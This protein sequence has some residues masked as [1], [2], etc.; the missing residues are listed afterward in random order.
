MKS[1]FIANIFESGYNS[2]PNINNFN[3]VGEKTESTDVFENP[4]KALIESLDATKVRYG[5]EIRQYLQLLWNEAPD[6]ADAKDPNLQEKMADILKGM[7][8]IGCAAPAEAV[9]NMHRVFTEYRGYGANEKASDDVEACF[10]EKFEI[11]ETGVIVVDT[12]VTR[13]LPK[14]VEICE[15]RKVDLGRIRVRCPRIVLAAQLMTM[16]P[17]KKAQME[18]VLSKLD[19]SQFLVE[20][21]NSPHNTEIPG[22][23][24]I[25]VHF[26]PRTLPFR[27]EWH[28]KAHVPEG[29]K[30]EVHGEVLT[31]LH[32]MDWVHEEV[33]QIIPGGRVFM[34]IAVVPKFEPLGVEMEKG[35][36]RTLVR[37]VQQITRYVAECIVRT[38]K[39]LGMEILD[40]EEFGPIAGY[41]HE[42]VI[43]GLHV[44]KP[45]DLGVFQRACQ[46]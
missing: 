21:A 26:T 43:Q 17:G 23:S 18:Q 42:K 40:G 33:A 27:L 30:E 11:P 37:P 28:E 19:K 45:K 20:D 10:G 22:S 12:F 14:I 31:S 4:R 46:T 25:A 2:P 41:D 44:R 38:L 32:Y 1:F 35:K 16:G 29:K 34:N 13:N 6:S 8:K 15:A 24:G 39:S 5:S 36:S 9:F 7:I 3:F